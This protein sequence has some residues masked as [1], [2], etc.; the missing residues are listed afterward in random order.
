MRR[1]V[2]VDAVL[3]REVRRAARL[4]LEDGRVA[5]VR[6]GGDAFGEL[7]AELAEDQE[8]R[9]VAH[10]VE[11]GDVPEGGRAAV[12]EDDLVAVWQGEQR[13][14]ALADPAHDV[15]HRRLPVRGADQV[16]GGGD[17]GQLLGTDLRRAA[18]EA[19][20]LGQQVCGD[21][22]QTWFPAGS[23]SL[24][25]SETGR[26]AGPTYF[27]DGRISLLSFFCS[28]MCALQPAVRA[29]VN[30]DVNMC[31]GTSAKSRTTADQNSTL[32]RSGRSG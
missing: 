16:A 13:R 28:R 10:Q 5:Q 17:R 32:V 18:A 19:A 21:L 8:L 1:R 2:D 26:G 15:L 9:A 27:A 24:G 11:G 14:H 31:A 20:V 6:R 25:T 29:Q 22:H 23:T 30:I 4:G 12:A 3:G 7:A